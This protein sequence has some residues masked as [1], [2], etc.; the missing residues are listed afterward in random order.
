MRRFG[1]FF[2]LLAML[3][4]SGLALR[5]QPIA[6]AQVATM[7]PGE[8]MEGLTFTLLGFAPGVTLP[9]AADL[10]VS[11]S[12]FEPG[13]GF[14]FDAS[15]PTGA[16]VIVEAGS[17]TITVEEQAW[18]ISRGAALAEAM[19][20]PAA[21][22]DLFGDSIEEIAMGAEGTL[23]TGDVAYVPGWVTGEVRNNGQEPASALLVLIGPSGGMMGEATPAP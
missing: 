22:T 5:A 9:S 16:L 23:E 4:L 12:E 3:M 7:E 8:S 13:A 10:E 14:P 18:T 20:S 6:V 21:G 11:R 15:E 1:V 2:S 17:L 19:A